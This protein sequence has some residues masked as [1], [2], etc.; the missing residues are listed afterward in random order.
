[1]SSYR[2]TLGA[3]THSGRHILT[4][5]IE[6]DAEEPSA[7]FDRARQEFFSRTA[8]VSGVELKARA[9][10]PL[11]TARQAV[12]G[13]WILLE[14]CWRRVARWEPVGDGTCRLF[15][16]DRRPPQPGVYAHYD[17]FETR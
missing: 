17:T 1:M 16:T 4:E 15:T 11:V 12:P 14:S 8:L 9:V 2:V 7:A 13:T 10:R 3:Y 6:V 5:K